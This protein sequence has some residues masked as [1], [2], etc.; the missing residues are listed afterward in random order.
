MAIEY[1]E[2][3]NIKWPKLTKIRERVLNLKTYL[4]K[5]SYFNKENCLIKHA[6]AYS[7]RENIFIQLSDLF[8]GAISYQKNK[9]PK[10][11]PKSE[12]CEFIAKNL[13]KRNLDLHSLP[14]ERKFNIFHIKLN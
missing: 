11:N 9:Y 12:I 6:Q 4:E 14:S 7:S 10:N 5:Y 2:K 3:G 1:D 8:C 13:K